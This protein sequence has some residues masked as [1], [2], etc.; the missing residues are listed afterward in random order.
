M[1]INQREGTEAGEEVT[2]I[3]SLYHIMRVLCNLVYV[4]PLGSRNWYS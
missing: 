2:Y 3:Q 1:Q 4:E